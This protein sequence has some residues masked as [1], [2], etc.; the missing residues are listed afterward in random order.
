MVTKWIGRRICGIEFANWNASNTSGGG[1]A[2][3][4]RLM[5]YDYARNKVSNPKRL[6][7]AE[8]EITKVWW[9]VEILSFLDRYGHEI[10]KLFER[11]RCSQP[12]TP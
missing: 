7:I 5:D 2:T 8:K 6:E 11:A 9:I 10:Q 4:G 12:S 1:P 3:G